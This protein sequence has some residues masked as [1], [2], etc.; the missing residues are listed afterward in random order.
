[1]FISQDGAINFLGMSMAAMAIK[2]VGCFMISHYSFD[3]MGNLS[4]RAVPA[5]TFA[6][7]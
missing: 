6:G 5:F 7:G 4:T 2:P 1:L 3:L